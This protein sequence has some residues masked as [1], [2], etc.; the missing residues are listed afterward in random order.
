MAGIFCFSS[1]RKTLRHW[2]I[3]FY[4][5][6]NPHHFKFYLLLTA[7]VSKGYCNLLPF[8]FLLSRVNIWMLLDSTGTIVGTV[9]QE[10]QTPYAIMWLQKQ[11][12]GIT[13][14]TNQS[15]WWNMG[16]THWQDFIWYGNINVRPWHSVSCHQKNYN[17][18]TT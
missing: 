8:L 15:W 9:I 13:S 12:H 1:S 4:Y 18:Q 16:Q 10:E 3:H 11:H 6:G 5:S 17:A 14:T 7:S 2:V